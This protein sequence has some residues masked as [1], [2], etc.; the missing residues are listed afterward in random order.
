MLDAAEIVVKYSCLCL[1]PGHGI[2]PRYFVGMIFE[3]GVGGVEG[4]ATRVSWP[5]LAAIQWVPGTGSTPDELATAGTQARP[6]AMILHPAGGSR[7]RTPAI[8][9]VS[10]PRNAVRG[11][12][13]QRCGTRPAGCILITSVDW[14][15]VDLRPRNVSCL[16]ANLDA[17]YPVRWFE[18][19]T[20]I[21][22]RRRDGNRIGL[23]A[24]FAPDA[25]S[26]ALAMRRCMRRGEGLF[27]P[28]TKE[29]SRVGNPA[30][31]VLTQF[32]TVKCV[33]N[34]RT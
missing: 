13:C 11:Q 15:A 5:G 30:G 12:P 33:R 14:L 10:D 24:V 31:C 34:K 4:H 28:E 20:G 32:G 9:P 21:K 8:S 29:R 7:E 23:P 22:P 27:P 19:T 2:P 17:T 18:S 6:D 26:T 25:P 3:I 16:A 1:P